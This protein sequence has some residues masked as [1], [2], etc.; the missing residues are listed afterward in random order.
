MTDR[1]LIVD[2][3]RHI[4]SGMK[5]ML[6]RNFSVETALGSEQGL[7]MVRSSGPFAV[8]LSDLKMP[9]MNGIEFLTKVRELSPATVRIMLTGHGDLDAAVKAVNLGEVF[10]F[11]TKPCSS[12]VL[13][14][15][16]KA[17]LEKYRKDASV[18]DSAFFKALQKLAA[19]NRP[20]PEVSADNR[21]AEE[22][23][24]TLSLR[25]RTIAAMIRKGSSTKEMA[26]HLNI[27]PRTVET[28]RDNIRRKLGLAGRK[29]NLQS[30][31]I[32]VE[33]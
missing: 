3:E 19:A 33:E 25:E 8:V 28:Y 16:L 32:S 31:L 6:R 9:G 17:G 2:D 21:G 18:E 10:R 11:Y 20:D 13:G 29:V 12:E 23:D 5:A 22:Q 30:V 15:A 4:L 26:E 24:N 1:I 7:E 27:S 14:E